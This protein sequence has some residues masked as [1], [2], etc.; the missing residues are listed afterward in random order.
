M[1]A[2]FWWTVPRNFETLQ[3]QSDYN[4]TPLFAEEHSLLK[5]LSLSENNT[6]RTIFNYYIDIT[7]NQQ[8]WEFFAPASPKWHQYIS[9]CH[10]FTQQP[11]QGRIICSDKPAFSNFNFSFKGIN[12]TT[13][14]DSRL[15]RLTENLSSL[16]DT[17]LLQAFNQYYQSQE[18]AEQERPT[19]LILHQFEL[20]PRLKGM[21]DEGYQMDSILFSGKL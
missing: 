13:A 5:A 21:P 14:D 10:N 12:F 6:L 15:Y 2:V 3:P 19:V 8:Y 9:I 11:Q 20:F 16:N 7:G 18:A 4:E 1:L 17:A